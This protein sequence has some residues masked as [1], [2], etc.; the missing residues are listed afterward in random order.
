M[1]VQQIPVWLSVPAQLF[2]LLTMIVGVIVFWQWKWTRFC[3]NNTLVWMRSAQGGI[4]RFAIP[5]IGNSI[6]IK[7][8]DKDGNVIGK[9]FPITEINTILVPYP[10]IGLVP[11]FLQ[12]QI[13]LTILDEENWEPALNFNKNHKAIASPTFLHN[14]IN[15][16]ITGFLINFTQ[17]VENKL[18]L[19][20]NILNPTHYYI[21]SGITLATVAFLVSKIIALETALATTNEGINLLKTGLGL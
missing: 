14:L 11:T 20:S 2:Y 12:K 17:E 10:G 7:T 1:E 13:Q 21:I 6:D 8:T 19:L 4:R 18:R 5:K 9:V 16:K 15:E 3:E